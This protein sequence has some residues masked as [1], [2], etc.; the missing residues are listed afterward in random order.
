MIYAFSDLHFGPELPLS[1]MLSETVTD[2]KFYSALDSGSKG[3]GVIYSQ[4]DL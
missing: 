2:G 1:A 3:Q 4:R